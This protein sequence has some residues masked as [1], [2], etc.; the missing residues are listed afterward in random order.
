MSAWLRRPQTIPCFVLFIS[1]VRNHWGWKWLSTCETYGRWSHPGI[2]SLS[3]GTSRERS[4]GCDLGLCCAILLLTWS[5]KK[6]VL[7]RGI[8]SSE[9]THGFP[10]LA[11]ISYSGGTQTL[12]TP[13]Q[14]PLIG[15]KLSETQLHFWITST[16]HVARFR[17]MYLK[18]RTSLT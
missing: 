9:S 18:V 4:E 13:T 15:Q 17:N 6:A 16:E 2:Q 8:L 3:W 7:S 5:N 11:E 1:T 10:S 14:L 12:C